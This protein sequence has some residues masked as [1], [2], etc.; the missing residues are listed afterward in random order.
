VWSPDERAIVF[1][2]A[3]SGSYELWKMGADGKGQTSLTQDSRGT[4]VAADWAPQATRA[5]VR[6]VSGRNRSESFY[7]VTPT[8]H[9]AP[10]SGHDVI[11]GTPF[12]DHL[13]GLGGP[14]SIHGL[15]T[16]DEI[17]GGSGNDRPNIDPAKNGIIAGDGGDD[18]IYAI[19]SSAPTGD[20]D[21]VNG[22][23][24]PD[25]AWVDRSPIP[26]GSAPKAPD[27]WV[28][29]TVVRPP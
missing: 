8:G 14:D 13:C 26:C 10:T 23:D 17:D 4:D 24:N 6:R 25:T 7:C 22:G 18:V 5:A 11:T 27:T 29:V 21:R 19:A 1:R 28:N 2:T 3:R 12:G 16:G 15:A 9:A 20:C